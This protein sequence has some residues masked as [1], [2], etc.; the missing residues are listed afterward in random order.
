[1]HRWKGRV[2]KL[3]S[4]HVVAEGESKVGY[5]PGNRVR[6]IEQAPPPQAEVPPAPVVAVVA[7]AEPA[8][9]AAASAPVVHTKESEARDLEGE[10]L[11]SDDYEDT[12][13]AHEE[14]DGDTAG[15][16]SPRTAMTVT[17]STAEPNMQP[18]PVWT[19]V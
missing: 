2:V 15:H 12:P 1:M 7:T 14:E 13:P 19:L 3:A 11:L 5:F 10:V 16:G 9:A 17:A 4:G 6:V 18:L 8:A